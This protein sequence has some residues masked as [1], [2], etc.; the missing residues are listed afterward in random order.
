M[1]WNNYGRTPNAAERKA[2]AQRKIVQL[3]KQGYELQPIGPLK[4]S[5]KIATSFWGRAWCHHLEQFSDYETRLPRG[6]SYLRQEAVLHLAIEPGEI[7]A[8]VLG[9]ELYELTI[10]IDPLSPDKWAELRAACQGQV[11]SLIELLQGKFADE[12]MDLVSDPDDGL[13]PLPQEIHFNCNCPDWADMCKHVAA[14]LYGVAARLDESPELLF[15]LRGVD[16]S[17]LITLKDASE[18][19]TQGQRKSKSRRLSE[20]AINDVFGLDE[21]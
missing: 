21:D 16:Q 17:E 5:R 15:T 19:L 12:V 18:S 13:F 20:D 10:Q 9:S 6:R 4:N 7:Q 8:M 1:S 14:V 2:K 11:A 3:R